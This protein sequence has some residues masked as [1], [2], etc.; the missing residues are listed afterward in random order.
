MTRLGLILA[1][2]VG[3][4]LLAAFVGPMLYD[5]SRFKPEIEARLEQALGR[6]VRIEGP[7]ALSLIPAPRF[8]A[9]DLVVANLPGGSDPV[10][11]RVKRLRLNLALLPL[12]SGG[13]KIDSLT[14]EEPSLLLEQLADG[15]PNWVFGK[16]EGQPQASQGIQGKGKPIRPPAADSND[17][18]ADIGVDRLLMREGTVTYRP[19]KGA[20]IRLDHFGADIRAASLA[21]PFD[22]KGSVVVGGVPVA[23][24]A[25]AGLF[26]TD[27]GTPLALD[28]RMQRV[29]ASVKFNGMVSHF[30]EGWGVRGKLSASAL[31]LDE[32]LREMSLATDLPPP[33]RAKLVL[34]SEVQ[35]GLREIAFNALTLR[36]GDTVANG[37]LTVLPQDGPQID[38][39]VA[40]P[41]LNLDKWLAGAARTASGPPSAAPPAPIDPGGGQGRPPAAAQPPAPVPLGLVLPAGLD[42]TVDLSADGVIWRGQ[43]LRQVSLHFGVQG[44]RIQ[45]HQGLA[46]LPASSE[47]R[48][49]G[50]F[51]DPG[52]SAGRGALEMRSDNLR[53]LLGWLGMT[54][55]DVPAD[56][57][58]RFSLA[59]AWQ[60]SGD[61]ISLS[62]VDVALDTS[63]LTGAGTVRLGRRLSFGI[64][65]AIDNIN[66]DAY[67]APP[68]SERAQANPAPDAAPAPAGAATP[69]PAKEEPSPGG[70][71][72]TALA[73]LDAEVKLGIRQVLWGS[74]VASGF[75]VDGTLWNGQ[76]KLRE[77]S[78]ADLGGATARLSGEIS[79]LATAPTLSDV[80]FSIAARQPGRL[81]RVFGLEGGTDW[82]RFGPASL[83]G[84]VSGPLEK[85]MVEAGLSAGSGT[86]AA[87]GTVV[88]LPGAPAGELA[89]DL[90]HPSFAQFAG[91]FSD[92]YRPSGTIGA[93][94]LKTSLQI[95]GAR[96]SL[97]DLE[98]HLGGMT[99]GGNVLA[100]WSAKPRIEADLSA[101]DIPVDA[102]LPGKSTAGLMRRGAGADPAAANP[103]RSANPSAQPIAAV[104]PAPAAAGAPWSSAPVDL[105]ALNAFDARVGLKAR[106]ATW[107]GTRFDAP[108]LALSLAKGRATLEQLDAGLFGGKVA[109]SGVLAT[110]PTTSLSARLGIEGAEVR[111]AMKGGGGL[112]VTAGK[113]DAQAELATT[114][115]STQDW[116][117]KLS[118]QGRFAVRDGTV[119]GFDL[120]EVNRRLANIENLTGLLGLVQAGLS[121]GQ[122]R[123]QSLAGTFQAR[124][125]IVTS[126]DL[127]LQ[128][129]GG[130]A[131]G[132]VRIDLPRYLLDARTGIRL[133]AASDAPPLG[134]R[135]E[136]ALDAPRKFVDIN[137]LQ[138]Y[139]LAKGLGRALKGKGAEGLLQGLLGGARGGA[140]S[141]PSEPGAQ[142]AP[143]EQGANNP[144]PS[145]GGKKPEDFVRDL[146]KGLGR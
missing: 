31:R 114:G 98:G 142:S 33:A 111:E 1:G 27:R 8:S 62:D 18:S 85:L 24:S 131:S 99:L 47:L 104:A 110:L 39:A 140:S 146:L 107:D 40:L 93:V 73:G 125:G 19:A 13:I 65:A 103:S 100:D 7:V 74:A 71:V 17:K 49:N 14:I 123:F 26:A 21:G 53:G 128:A 43:A 50:S 116:A 129:D 135:L 68:P 58:R 119:T 57:M 118:G 30:S 55:P 97:S 37:A 136:G 138:R 88:G 113:L 89:L 10:M 82:G 42:A 35:G 51:D 59:G 141:G 9:G 46:L 77:A 56:R 15:T 106:S 63:R 115:A 41:N 75:V 124:N 121:G 32:A 94:A 36:I 28:L 112:A 81:M 127:R 12:I 25:A 67:R 91:M 6:A 122:T 87:K 20:P 117:N 76:L 133:A 79:G 101:G 109:L 66:V 5:W 78:V 95:D 72:L 132:T 92:S 61:L 96:L 102:L 137:D 145:P 105:A 48:F 4:L 29:D 139:L 54:M 23:F 143:S 126:E 2:L 34:E 38:L 44:G 134:I 70:G 144:T 64:D 52:V 130:S 60:T 108:I 84:A 80:S 90:A 86:L 69:L 22:A 3:V 45:V 83:K 11:A 16:A 120:P